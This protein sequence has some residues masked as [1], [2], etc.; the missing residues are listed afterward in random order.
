MTEALHF[1]T[2]EE[3]LANRSR[4]IGASEAAQVIGVSPWG[5]PIDLWK[6]KTG[7]SKAKD[8][9][10]NPNVRLG[11]MLE[12]PLRTMFSALHPEYEVSY[13]PYDIIFQS[14]NPWLYATLDGELHAEDGHT[15]ILEIKTAN[16]TSKTEWAEWNN[17]VPP[18][19]YAQICHQLLATDFE[20]AYLFAFLQGMDKTQATLRE[21]RFDKA[22]CVEDMEYLLTEEIEFWHYVK[23]NTMP[24]QK[25]TL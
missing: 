1:E 12:P 25:L 18:K 17:Q 13:K 24:P 19:Y 6:L 15:G 20:F 10:D 23:T 2:R 14:E 5:T 9:G 11:V 16:P 22:D 3:W 21:Y 4:G 8:L 7:K